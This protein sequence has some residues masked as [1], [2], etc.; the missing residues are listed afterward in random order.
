MKGGPVTGVR[1]WILEPVFHFVG[2]VV[3]KKI[4]LL[5]KPLAGLTGIERKSDD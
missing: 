1:R 3:K 4:Q 5:S 2:F